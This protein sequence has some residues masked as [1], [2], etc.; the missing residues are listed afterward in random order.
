MVSRIANKQALIK[1]IEQRLLLSYLSTQSCL[2]SLDILD[3][4][5]HKIPIDCNG[6]KNDHLFTEFS[7]FLYSESMHWNLMST[8][9]SHKRW[10]SQYRREGTLIYALIVMTKNISTW[11]EI[12][13]RRQH[14]TIKQNQSYL[15]KFNK[16]LAERIEYDWVFAN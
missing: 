8:S 16:I 7:T 3:F 2:W 5:H 15:V 12:G 6:K 10:C 14:K 13:S 9:I 1:S 11:G 4:P